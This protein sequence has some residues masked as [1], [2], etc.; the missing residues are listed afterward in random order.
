MDRSY[1]S[2][3]STSDVLELS[4]GDVRRVIFASSLGT[5]FEWYDF[6]LYGSLA[7]II[8]KQFFAGVRMPILRSS[9]PCWHS[10]PGLPCGRLAHWCS[11]ALGTWWGER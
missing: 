1:G 2:A 3:G 9:S 6:Y 5:V 4:A 11:G 7:A 8:S 10:R